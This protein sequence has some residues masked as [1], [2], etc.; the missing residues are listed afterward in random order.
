MELES[1]LCYCD[2][3]Y[4][5]TQLT[6]AIEMQIEGE[7]KVIKCSDEWHKKVVSD[8]AQSYNSIRE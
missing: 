4:H 7:Y 8:K 6:I 5:M 2:I 1:L 3:V